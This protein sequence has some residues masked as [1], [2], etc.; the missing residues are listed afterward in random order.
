MEYAPESENYLPAPTFQYT[1]TQREIDY[2]QLIAS[3]VE[4]VEALRESA[5]VSPTE[6]EMEDISTLK[7]MASK[8]F[9]SPAVA[10]RYDYYLT[11]HKASMSLTIKRMQQELAAVAYADF[12][13]AYTEDGE[14][15]TNPHEIPRYLRAA[16]K[17]FGFDNN[18]QPRHKY[19]DKIKATQLLG[20]LTGHFDAAHAAKAPQV[21]VTL[22]SQSTPP[23]PKVV[24]VTPTQ[25]D[26]LS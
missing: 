18:G 6:Y 1:P 4:P 22:S 7:K 16:I 13:L 21:N 5:L 8:L 17:E 2:A 25:V 26:P 19:H 12:A 9:I 20:D 15:I 24:D 11:L 10:E 3:G 23:Q 14:P